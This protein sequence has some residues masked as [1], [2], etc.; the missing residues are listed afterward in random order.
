MR[1]SKVCCIA[2]NKVLNARTS[3]KTLEGVGAR[4]IL[5]VR[6]RRHILQIGQNENIVLFQ[7]NHAIPNKQ[8]ILELERLPAFYNSSNVYPCSDDII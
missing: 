3:K 4:D 5:R 6:A 2:K 7:R 8:T 1:Y